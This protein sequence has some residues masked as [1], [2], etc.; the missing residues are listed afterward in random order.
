MAISG[1]GTQADPYIVNNWDD[2]LTVSSNSSNYVKF[3]N[4]S[5]TI[6]GD[7]SSSN[8]FI[9][10]TYE[11]ML[12][13]TGATYIHQVKLIDREA[14]KYKYNDVYCIYDDSLTTIDF[15]DVYPEGTTDDLAIYAHVDYNG[16]TFRNLTLRYRLIHSYRLNNI[17]M[18]NTIIRISTSSVNYGVIMSEGGIKNSI[19]DIYV[20]EMRSSTGDMLFYLGGSEATGMNNCSINLGSSWSV[21]LGYG[22]IVNSKINLD[23]HGTRFYIGRRRESS[24]SLNNCLLTGTVESTAAAPILGNSIRNTIYDVEF[25]GEPPSDDADS[26][27]TSFY[28]SDKVTD[29]SSL[30]HGL[31]PATTEQLKDA[32]WLYDHG[33][34]IGVD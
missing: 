5:R 32:Q 14:K 17:R 23:V 9:V 7:G 19:F 30:T 8:P 6:T 13:K 2:F 15:N 20:D 26:L 29:A 24:M 16:W 28:N 1:S 3:A 25:I 31:I 12:T 4:P 33:L 18:I 11:E 22:S 34:P 21:W 27:Y 10:S